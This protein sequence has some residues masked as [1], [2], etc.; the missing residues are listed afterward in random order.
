MRHYVSAQ[1]I[2]CV[3][4]LLMVVKSDES[5]SGVSEVTLSFRFNDEMKGNVDESPR[6]SQTSR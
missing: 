6:R 2:G 3:N 1:F 4:R 5:A